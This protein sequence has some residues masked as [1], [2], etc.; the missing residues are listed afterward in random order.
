MEVIAQGIQTASTERTCS[1]ADGYKLAETIQLSL[2]TQN[3][4][5]IAGASVQFQ[6]P[7]QV[8]PAPK[9][10][11]IDAKG[12][13]HIPGYAAAGG[14]LMPAAA[15]GRSLLGVG[16]MTDEGET[17]ELMHAGRALQQTQLYIVVYN[18]L[19]V[20]IAATQPNV[21]PDNTAIAARAAE[22]EAQAS[23]PA[24]VN[25]AFPLQGQLFTAVVAQETQQV[26][27]V[28]STN[29][30]T[31]APPTNNT[32][33]VWN[34]VAQ[35]II[36]TNN[37]KLSCADALRLGQSMALSFRQ[38]LVQTGAANGLAGP[39]VFGGTGDA[40]GDVRFGGVEG[41]GCTTVSQ[42]LSLLQV[43]VYR[44][45]QDLANWLVDTSDGAPFGPCT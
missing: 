26:V 5:T 18:M 21:P 2:S 1:D 24:T 19:S 45:N 30:A 22:I 20:I 14:M 44:G 11:Y 3:T 28:A 32:Q 31:E 25:E 16:T 7:C 27:I 34:S 43:V 37:N 38:N 36:T 13:I 23:N 12:V 4:T 15:R 40:G 41:D 9:T 10:A 42:G 29:N 33:S 6:P 35:R 17:Q 39:N 8:A